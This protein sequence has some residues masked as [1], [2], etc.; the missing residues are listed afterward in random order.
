MSDFAFSRVIEKHRKIAKSSPQ[1][2]SAVIASLL[3]TQALKYYSGNKAVIIDNLLTESI[4]RLKVDIKNTTA[5]IDSKYGE[6]EYLS[7]EAVCLSCA[8]AHAVIQKDVEKDFFKSTDTKN[9]VKILVNLKLL[10]ERFLSIEFD[11]ECVA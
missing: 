10:P 9:Q 6:D 2:N 8:T 11:E 1:N 3:E 4:N 5:F 7:N